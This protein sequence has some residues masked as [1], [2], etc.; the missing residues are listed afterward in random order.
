MKE[1]CIEN[2]EAAVRGDWYAARRKSPS[3]E[4]FDD[5][6]ELP[7]YTLTLGSSNSQKLVTPDVSP[8]SIDGS[9]HDMS[10]VTPPIVEQNT[11]TE[12][13]EE[14]ASAGKETNSSSEFP[15]GATQRAEQ[16]GQ[17][18]SIEQ[19]R[20]TGSINGDNSGEQRDIPRSAFERM[21]PNQGGL[22]R[23][24]TVLKVLVDFILTT[25]PIIL[26]FIKETQ[27]EGWLLTHCSKNYCEWIRLVDDYLIDQRRI[28]IE[29][30]I[31]SDWDITVNANGRKVY[32]DSLELTHVERSPAAV[33]EVRRNQ[34]RF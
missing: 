29:V 25:V 23:N 17:N 3:R 14:D 16:A 9:V 21:P 7:Q 10:E 30:R 5:A 22:S 13:S 4:S 28:V 8:E 32:P 19:D 15:Q 27:A 6:K 18:D 11:K 2:F 24:L 26:F 33:S 34:Y 12:P 1:D 20:D 31:Q